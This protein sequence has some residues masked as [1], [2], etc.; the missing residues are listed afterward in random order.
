MY[1]K[2]L[3]IT[4]EGKQLK[5]F[6]LYHLKGTV[7]LVWKLKKSVKIVNT[8]YVEREGP[9]VEETTLSSFCTTFFNLH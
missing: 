3:K 2:N 7:L 9:L 1:V 4:L 5:G 6:S 8:V